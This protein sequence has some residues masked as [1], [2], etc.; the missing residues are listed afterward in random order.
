M[1][2]R[3][4]LRSRRPPRPSRESGTR[5]TSAY[6]AVAVSVLVLLAA[7]PV[8]A[9]I[10][11][12]FTPIHLAKQSDRILCLEVGAGTE[13][14]QLSVRIV[15]TVKGETLARFA[16][17]VADEQL[18]GILDEEVF[19]DDETQPGMAFFGKLSEE[20]KTPPKAPVPNAPVP[21]AAVISI[22]GIW[23]GLAA[24]EKDGEWRLVEDTRD[25]KA[26]WDGPS[27]MLRRCIQYVL[28]DPGA[29]VPV[30]AG[31]AWNQTIQI[32]KIEGAV[33]HATAVD[34]AGRGR[35]SLFVAGQ[36]G[37]RVFRCDPQTKTFQDVTAARK[38]ASKS[39]WA[40]F[41]DFNT[42][43]ALDLAS[44][45]GKTLAVWQQSAGGTFETKRAEVALPGGCRELSVVDV[46]MPGRAGL[47]VNTD[48]VPLLVRPTDEGTFAAAKLVEMQED[49]F[50]GADMGAVRACLT[51]DFDGDRRADVLQVFEDGG[52]LYRGK[53]AGAFE[54]PTTCGDLFSDQQDTQAYTG[55]FD[56]DGRLDV[57]FM[58]G[59]GL[60]LWRNLGEGKFQQIF[61]TGEPD[62]IAKQ[63]NS[64]G[65]VCDFN[66]DGRQDFLVLYQRAAPH[67]FFSRGFAC[68]GFAEELDVM[69]DDF[70]RPAGVGQ[71]AGTVADLNHD[72]AQDMALVLADGTVWVVT[73]AVEE[74]P[75][76]CARAVLAPRTGFAGPLT[77]TGYQDERCLGAWNVT[78][79]QEAFF[80]SEVPGPITL[81]W[82][83]PD[84]APQEQEVIVE[85]GPVRISIGK[86]P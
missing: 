39:R 49:A 31:V 63:G 3:K 81:R 43:G 9:L 34:L 20:A 13:D 47:V 32:G 5:R 64:G 54:P 85:E 2:G 51:A 27:E 48:R 53:A 84:G 17:H 22:G 4:R 1:S 36:D 44:S 40:E 21:D 73:R 30:R 29:A 16:L 46:G 8:V 12:N 14:G 62:Y 28:D 45:D 56:A 57:I 75:A 66:N 33:H 15:K 52:L 37:D 23:F 74:E 11:P 26:V 59:D 38:L 67:P 24:G 58:G 82:Q 71:Q 86:S 10:N 69:R 72:G 83:F 79:A 55:D 35:L 6:V 76:L 60:M 42:D 77:V 18:I 7:D 25:M 65:A 68:F 50:P 19:Y 80:G 41:A 78:R 61:K 70:F